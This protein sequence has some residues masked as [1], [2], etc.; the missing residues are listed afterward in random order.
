MS[1]ANISQ[2]YRTSDIIADLDER[3][4]E[5]GADR[6]MFSRREV[7]DILVELQGF[8]ALLLEAYDVAVLAKAA[9][10]YINDITSRLQLHN[11]QK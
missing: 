1:T 7:E 6:F 8:E 9:Q 10:N 4:E 5:K 11:N 3:L 2:Q